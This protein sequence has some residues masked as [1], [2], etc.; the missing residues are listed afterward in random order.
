MR[1]RLP[2]AALV[3]GVLLLGTAPLAADGA[4]KRPMKASAAPAPEAPAAPEQLAEPEPPAAPARRGPV[5]APG[6]KIEALPQLAPIT[7]EERA[8][9]DGPA[10]PDAP[11]PPPPE[12]QGMP[13]RAQAEDTPAAKGPVADPA[14]ARSSLRADEFQYVFSV[15]PGRPKAGTPVELSWKIQEILHIPDPFLGDRKP[16]TGAKLVATISGP[17]KSRTF[18][19]HPMGA[20]SSGVYGLHFTPGTNGAYEIQ[21]ARADGKSGHKVRFTAYVGVEPPA[22]S[23]NLRGVNDRAEELIAGR[24]PDDRS[25]EGVMKELG[26]RWMALERA[27]GTP[28]AGAAVEEL[29]AQV[30]KI[31]GKAPR[32]HDAHAIE[33]DDLARLLHSRVEK[34]SGDVPRA[35]ALDALQEVQEQACLRCHVR[36]RFGLA[37]GVRNWP[38]FEEKK[39]LDQASPRDRAPRG[40]GPVAPTR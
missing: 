22:Q 26:K 3:A 23:T 29:Q 27:A 32:R 1:H 18:E 34:L 16:A 2:R 7:P 28:Q 15:K 5:V 17:E 19:V 8:K 31:A 25:I 14:E 21:L 13:V 38:A 30:A 12:F 39:D 33:F 35:A 24:G 36:F 10:E 20:S 6:T 9:K 11:P 4:P 37:D 40:R